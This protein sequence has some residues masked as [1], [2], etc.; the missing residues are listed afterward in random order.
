MNQPQVVGSL[1]AVVLLFLGGEVEKS[2]VWM[3]PLVKGGM[4]VASGLSH[5]ESFYFHPKCG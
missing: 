4:L 3:I 1:V 5:V 2:E